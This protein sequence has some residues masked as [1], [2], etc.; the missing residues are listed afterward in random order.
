MSRRFVAVA[1]ACLL[2]AASVLWSGCGWLRGKGDAEVE[3]VLLAQA[4]GNVI[5][6]EAPTVTL[7]K[8]QRADEIELPDAASSVRVAIGREVSYGQAKTL[9][10]RVEKAGKRPIILV[11][12]RYKLRSIELND[13]LGSPRSAIR[14]VATPDGKACV[15][16]PDN[17]ESKCVIQQLSDHVSTAYVREFVREAVKGYGLDEVRVFVRPSVE[18]ADVIRAIDGAR[19]CCDHMRPKVRLADWD[20]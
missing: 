13:E 1:A 6:A 15:A 12:Q 17:P 20:S 11:G 18:W 3:G 4:D 10:K 8:G 16:P 19:T 2:S 7:D 9:I 14:L 5:A